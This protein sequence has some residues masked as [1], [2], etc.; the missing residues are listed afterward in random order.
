MRKKGHPPE[1][2]GTQ[3]AS[4]RLPH[5][6]DEAERLFAAYLETFQQAPESDFL[7]KRYF[8]TMDFEK[9]YLQDN[10]FFIP[11]DDFLWFFKFFKTEKRDKRT[12]ELKKRSTERAKQGVEIATIQIR[13]HYTYE[14][15]AAD[16]IHTRRFADQEG[17]EFIMKNTNDAITQVEKLLAD[18]RDDRVMS[19]P[20]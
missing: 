15:G 12:I 5:L 9:D 10:V 17:V 3:H 20:Y 18:F 14:E 16:I 13:T 4:Q 7:L 19:Q 2:S 8:F 6:E 11:R 1:E